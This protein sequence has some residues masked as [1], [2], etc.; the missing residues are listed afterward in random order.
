MIYINNKEKLEEFKNARDLYVV[1][2]FD[3]TLTTNESDASMGIIP[4]FLGGEL[5]A[6]RIKIHDYY[7]PLELDYT[8]S[9]EE[10]SKIMK[11]WATTSFTLLSKYLNSEETIKNALENANIGLRK[12]VKEFLK[13]M[14]E[15]DVPV[16]IMSAGMGNLIKIFLEKQGVLYDNI[17][18]ISNFFKFRDNKSYIDTNNLI[19]P[20][21]KDYSKIPEEIRNELDKKENIL[22]F[23][24]IVEDIKMVEKSKINKTLTVGF[25][26]NNIDSNLEVYN[27]NFDIVLADNETFEV[28]KKVIKGREY[29]K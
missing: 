16:I 18:L 11:E 7:R 2:D 23:G 28:V 20:S 21:T 6:E 14:H 12:G 9:K 4:K 8:L 25:L 3:R 15:K 5:L 19:S 27:K 24:D 26:D 10:R 22:L 17:I 29:E 13:Y 1:I